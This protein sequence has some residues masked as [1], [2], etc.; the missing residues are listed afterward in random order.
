MLIK[1]CYV[2]KKTRLMDARLGTYL[3]FSFILNLYRLYIF[4]F[5]IIIEDLIESFVL[6]SMKCVCW[7]VA[8]SF[9]HRPQVQCRH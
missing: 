5:P 6:R 8:Y 1:A 9:R 2:V 7:F 3:L 4:L